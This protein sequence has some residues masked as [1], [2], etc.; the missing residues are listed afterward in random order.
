MR[1]SVR[2]GR[3]SS[4]RATGRVVAVLATAAVLALAGAPPST[5]HDVL[6]ATTPASG[7]TV[8]TVPDEIV[9][10]FD[11]PAFAT[12]TVLV[13]RDPGGR[14]VA[15]GPPTLV[16]TTVRQ[17][18]GGRLPAGTYTVLWRVT[19]AD[20]HPV[21]GTFGFVARVGRVSTV[22]AGPAPPADDAP[23]GP[24]P[25]VPALGVA[26]LLAVL[27]VVVVRRRPAGRQG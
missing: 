9:L 23:A 7:S 24:L 3:G 11:Q 6:T 26:V 8:Q 2:A 25:L 17:A 27:V 1:P 19:S 13:V 5:A 12:G 20:G 4:V 18:V 10:T 15:V 14:D 22:S 16:D 21:D